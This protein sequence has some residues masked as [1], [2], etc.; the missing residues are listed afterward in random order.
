MLTSTKKVV[1]LDDGEVDRIQDEV[2]AFKKI[3]EINQTIPPDEEDESEEEDSE[4]DLDA[5]EEERD[6]RYLEKE[7]KR[8]ERVQ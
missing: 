3:I 2:D 8:K 6:R 5:D 4:S 1:F 7:R